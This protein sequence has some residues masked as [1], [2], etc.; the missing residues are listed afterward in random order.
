MDLYSLWT[1]W[2]SIYILNIIN[3]AILYNLLFYIKKLQPAFLLD[4]V[5]ACNLRLI[6]L[7]SYSDLKFS[8][9]AQKTH[10][11]LS[12]QIL[13]F[14]IDRE[15]WL[16]PSEFRKKLK[17]PCFSL[18]EKPPLCLNDSFLFFPVAPSLSFWNLMFDEVW[19]SEKT[20]SS[21]I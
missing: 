14:L 18:W 10:E 17:T 13:N 8:L 5:I 4:I 21:P 2:Q 9:A 1:R 20:Y 6:L 12:E 16:K 11:I 15:N 7:R 3:S 19:Q